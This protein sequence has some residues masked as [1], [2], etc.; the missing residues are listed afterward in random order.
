MRRKRV[1]D[2]STHSDK[3][4]CRNSLPGTWRILEVE[5]ENNN[6]QNSL[7]LSDLR[8]PTSLMAQKGKMVGKGVSPSP[9]LLTSFNRV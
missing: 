4:R 1:N 6:P 2:F 5:A 3:M 9:P 7:V 8:N